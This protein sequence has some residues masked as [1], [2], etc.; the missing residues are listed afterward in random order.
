[1]TPDWVT[2]IW[3]APKTANTT[4]AYLSK[5]FVNVING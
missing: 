1:M 4:P 3:N 2:A 5:S